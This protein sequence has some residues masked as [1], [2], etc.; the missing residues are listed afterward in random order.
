MEPTGASQRIW[1]PLL[2]HF[3]IGVSLWMAL[4][5]AANAADCSLLSALNATEH[6]AF[7]QAVMEKGGYVFAF[8]HTA[9]LK[10]G[11]TWTDT[12]SDAGK[13]EAKKAGK[14]F[15]ALL[16]SKDVPAQIFQKHYE[17]KTRIARTRELF[18]ERHPYKEYKF[19]DLEA[20]LDQES[21]ITE[22]KN[23][24][25]FANSIVMNKFC[26]GTATCQLG[27]MEAV[28]FARTADGQRGVCY[29]FY[30]AEWE[31]RGA[32][33]PSWNETDKKCGAG[34]R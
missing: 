21:M 32:A 12:L 1:R 27:C 20:F 33:L 8:R 2:I 30:P 10:D 19:N 25:V 23:T 26:D 31:S 13:A 18:S 34:G 3:L 15:A 4:G 14:I 29:R 22:S 28:V 9:R 6:A 17:G 16:G 7:K 24:F 5:T 11:D